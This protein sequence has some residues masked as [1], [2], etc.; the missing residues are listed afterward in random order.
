MKF[1]LLI[2]ALLMSV[3]HLRAAPIVEKIIDHNREAYRLSDGQTQAIVVP[4]YSGRVMFYGKVG[5]ANWLW[6]APAE[7]LGGEG[8][9]N[10]GG[11]KTFVGPHGLWNLFAKSIWPPQPSW[12][13]KPHS[14]EV[15]PG[16][17]LRT[18]GPVWDGFGARIIREYS[19][20]A[21]GA[22]VIRQTIEKVRGG[23]LP[24]SIWS[25]RGRE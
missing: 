16:G 21:N 24:M 10:Y 22:F 25:V 18:V 2:L 6:N 11:D 5:G 3:H 12:D 8:F 1:S 23:A 13:G 14:A 7:K 4:D 15:L 17:R 20:D 9:Q 19:F